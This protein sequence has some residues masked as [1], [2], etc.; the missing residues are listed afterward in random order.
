MPY[1]GPAAPPT[2]EINVVA[3]SFSTPPGVSGGSRSSN[4]DTSAVN[5]R[6][7]FSPWSP[8]PIARSSRTSSSRCS[9]TTAA[10]ARIAATTSSAVHAT[11]DSPPQRGRVDRRVPQLDQ[12]VV[13]LEQR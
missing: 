4:L 8:S 1:S 7:M 10:A 5:P 6:L 11:S 13:Q 12:L 2:V 9:T 3:T